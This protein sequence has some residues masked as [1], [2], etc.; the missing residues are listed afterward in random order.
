MFLCHGVLM[1]NLLD[2]NDPKVV[3]R[4]IWQAEMLVN[5]DGVVTFSIV[6]VLIYPPVGLLFFEF[7]YILL[8]VVAPIAPGQV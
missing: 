8:P 4:M 2:F 5:F 3:E 6:P 1:F 7:P